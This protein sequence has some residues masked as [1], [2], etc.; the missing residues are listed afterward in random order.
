MVEFII[1]LGI[2]LIY[3]GAMVFAVY[4][5]F[6]YGYEVGKQ[7]A[8]PAPKFKA[9]PKQRLKGDYSEGLSRYFGEELDAVTPEKEDL[10][11]GR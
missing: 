7:Q 11:D 10:S 5:A 2:G 6:K 4:K 8:K 1:A 9:P 3:C